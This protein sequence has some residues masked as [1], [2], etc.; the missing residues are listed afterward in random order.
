M[1]LQTIY[2]RKAK[3]V[4]KTINLPM[5]DWWD[6][7]VPQGNHKMG[8]RRIIN[9]SD[10]ISKLFGEQFIWTVVNNDNADIEIINGTRY[11]NRLGFI[12]CENKWEANTDIFVKWRNE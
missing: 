8:D 10:L 6:K 7:Y 11:C 3:K 9:E 4:R 5:R 12:V 2:K 1:N